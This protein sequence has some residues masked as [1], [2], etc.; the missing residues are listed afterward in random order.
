MKQ[1]TP[2]RTAAHV[3]FRL[4]LLSNSANS[5][6]F[7]L[8]LEDRARLDPTEAFFSVDLERS[9]GLVRRGLG[10]ESY[11]NGPGDVVSPETPD[12]TKGFFSVSL[13]RAV[14]IVRRELGNEGHQKHSGDG[15][16]EM[17]DLTR[18]FFSVDLARALEKFRKE[19]DKEQ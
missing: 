1:T 16:P 18:N 10:S 9:I 7:R 2:L 13:E 3:K 6:R 19:L 12:P 11:G 5:R 8:S 14:E 17:P 4:A 15:S